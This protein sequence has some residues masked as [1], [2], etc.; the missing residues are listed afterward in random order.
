MFLFMLKMKLKFRLL[1]QDTKMNNIIG[2]QQQKNVLATPIANINFCSG[3]CKIICRLHFHAPCKIFP[4]TRSQF[5]E[6][7]HLRGQF[8]PPGEIMQKAVNSRLIIAIR[9]GR[10]RPRYNPRRVESSR[11]SCRSGIKTEGELFLIGRS[12]DDCHPI[13]RRLSR[14][15]FNSESCGLRENFPPGFCNRKKF[16]RLLAIRWEGVDDG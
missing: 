16:F 8:P 9:G 14:R 7:T 15:R 11:F 10:E 5:R 1:L 2:N 6:E 4:A 12:A 13:F 3:W